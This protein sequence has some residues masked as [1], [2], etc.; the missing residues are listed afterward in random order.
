MPTHACLNLLH[1]LL[2]KYRTLSK[3]RFVT[4]KLRRESTQAVKVYSLGL[5]KTNTDCFNLITVFHG[6]CKQLL[7][8]V[9]KKP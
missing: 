2:D 5:S 4:Y 1:Y 9:K 8:K 7:L 3:N 6:H